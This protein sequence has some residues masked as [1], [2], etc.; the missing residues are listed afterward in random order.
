[1]GEH[2]DMLVQASADGMGRAPFYV[3]SLVHSSRSHTG[4]CEDVHTEE[5]LRAW[6]QGSCRVRRALRCVADTV[7]VI[8][9][10]AG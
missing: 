3:G 6:C 7:R 2:P 5:R 1:M 4:D 10:Q 9:D 8:R